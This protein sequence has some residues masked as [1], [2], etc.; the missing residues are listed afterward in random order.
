MRPLSRSRGPPEAR[1]AASGPAAQRSARTGLV[2]HRALIYPTKC[3]PTLKLPPAEIITPPPLHSR[4]LDERRVRSVAVQ[5]SANAPSERGGGHQSHRFRIVSSLS[6]RI[7]WTTQHRH[8]TSYGRGMCR[9]L[10]FFASHIELYIRIRHILRLARAHRN[11]FRSGRKTV[12]TYGATDETNRGILE[13][14]DGMVERYN[15]IEK[16]MGMKL[17][18]FAHFETEDWK[19]WC[20]GLRGWYRSKLLKKIRK[21]PI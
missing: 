17:Q 18:C 6:R 3:A 12:T 20:R 2:N 4:G 15:H 21:V 5:S 13:A 9:Q 11:P 14:H 8:A 16:Q 1:L 19:D 7:T 10:S